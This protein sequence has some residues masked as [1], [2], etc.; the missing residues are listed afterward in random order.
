MT[1]R[2]RTVIAVALVLAAVIG[3]WLLFVAPKRSEASRLASQLDSVRAQLRT[4]EAAVASGVA[5]RD[6]YG[7]YYAELA[8]LGEAVP[9]TDDVPSLIYE[10]Q[11]AASNAGVD[12][13]SLA[14]TGSGSGAS[15]SAASGNTAATLPPG[16]SESAAGLPEEPFTLTFDGSFFHLANFLGR[17][18]H[19]V[20]VTDKE[21]AVSGRLMSLNS[22]SLQA[23][24][25]GFPQITATIAATTYLLAA[26]EPTV[27]SS[28]ATG[29]PVAGTTS[30]AAAP[31]SAAAIA[32]PVK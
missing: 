6:A 2:D 25:H 14:L 28:P 12:F 9:A 10:V 27:R 1:S 11:S 16:V 24:P 13:H 7:A 30:T 3:S 29:T 23:G 5:A 26:G 31:S 15:S 17:L 32:S 22:L 8:R 19:F 20:T 18:Q 4:E 21:V